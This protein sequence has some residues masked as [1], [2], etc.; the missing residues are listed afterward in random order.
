MTG[1]GGSSV[2]GVPDAWARG[3]QGPAYFACVTA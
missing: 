3:R 2:T 1:F